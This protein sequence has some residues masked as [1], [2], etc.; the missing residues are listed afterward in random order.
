MLPPRLLQLL[1][2]LRRK[3]PGWGT[4]FLGRRHQAVSSKMVLQAV[5]VIGAAARLARGWQLKVALV[6]VQHEQSVSGVPL[7]ALML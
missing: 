5:P 2:A 7:K 3:G 4:C 1:P 6:Q